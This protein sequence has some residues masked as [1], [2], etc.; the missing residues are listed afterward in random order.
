MLTNAEAEPIAYFKNYPPRQ[1][2]NVMGQWRPQLIWPVA[3][4][5]YELR[6]VGGQNLGPLPAPTPAHHQKMPTGPNYCEGR[7]L[8]NSTTA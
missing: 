7:G 4:H 5:K 2:T 8:T 1:N 3:T 6:S